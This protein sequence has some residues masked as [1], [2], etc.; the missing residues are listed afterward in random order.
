MKTHAAYDRLK[1]MLPARTAPAR[2]SLLSDPARLR[3]WL[4]ELPLAN[5]AF[6]LMRLEEVL[7][8]SNA[9][10]I[11]PQA[12][13]AM[14]EMLEQTA[15][16]LVD[17][18]NNE[19]REF[20]P[21]SA[22]R[23]DSAQHAVGIERE[24]ALGYVEVI[25]DL[26]APDGKVPLLRGGSVSRALTRACQH[27][28]AQLWQASRTHSAP[29]EGVWRGMHNVFSFAVAARR[30]D[31]KSVL[32]NGTRTSPRSLYIQ[33]LLHAFAKSN[34][35]TQAQNRQLRRSLPVLASW[36]DVRQGHAAM[37]MIAVHALSDQSPPSPRGAQGDAGDHWMLD[38]NP[39]L[40][41]FKQALERDDEDEVRLRAH[42]GGEE[43]TLAEEVVSVLGRVWRERTER[44]SAR[45]ADSAML[46]TE[47]GLSGLHYILS[48]NQD[49]ESVLPLTDATVSTASWAQRAPGRAPTRRARAEA[50]DQ[51]RGGYRLHWAAGEDARAR[52]G[53]LIA[54]APVS[55]GERQWSFGALRWLRA[56][57]RDGVDAGVEL[58]AATPVAVAVYALDES[59]TPRAP[60]RGL[61][62]G[63][64]N[65]EA[66][67]EAG[68]FVPKP[69]PRDAV[70]LEVLR[71]DE[72]AAETMLRPARVV[73]FDL[74]DAGL[75][76]KILLASEEIE[77]IARA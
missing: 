62:V 3:A 47:V 42:R 16:A 8:E 49:F 33:A 50:I 44:G 23:M 70:A 17:D 75:Y 59:G 19:V 30:A 37:G 69:F 53:E 14:L 4:A 15:N 35:F 54:I 64:G 21:M 31:R 55:P 40:A 11:P 6:A 41:Q 9:V 1:S 36:C 65:G 39:L 52:V 12:R 46:E 60:V 20:F 61:L 27:Q 72:S 10:E 22:E 48:G 32:A 73:K 38:V 58:L 24:F 57:S 2:D 76:Q 43:A 56:D 74:R 77:R 18:E 28:S 5:R 63:S 71:V 25:C 68:I 51:S 67:S 34:Q 26:C 29:A 7:R 66:G 45:S 13:L